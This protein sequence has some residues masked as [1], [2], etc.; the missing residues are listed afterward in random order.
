MN[1]AIASQPTNAAHYHALGNVLRESGRS[2]EAIRNFQHALALRPD[3]V[4]RRLGSWDYRC[5]RRTG[6]EESLAFFERVTIS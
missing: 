2:E 6:W 4:E 5:L 3:F 1:R